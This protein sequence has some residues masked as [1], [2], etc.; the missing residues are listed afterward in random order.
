MESLLRFLAELSPSTH[1]TASMTL[2][3][4][5]PF[6]PTIQDIL[7]GKVT[8]VGSTKDLNPDSLMEFSL[9]M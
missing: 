8:E 2:D 5:Q 3:F 7:D 9:M 4:P 6:G 1:R